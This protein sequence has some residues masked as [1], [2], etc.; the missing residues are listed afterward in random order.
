VEVI[1]K[2]PL[3]GSLKFEEILTFSYWAP[4]ILILFMILDSAGSGIKTVLHS[5]YRLDMCYLV[6]TTIT[7]TDGT[8]VGGLLYHV[9]LELDT[10]MNHLPSNQTHR[11]LISF[12]GFRFW[13]LLCLS[14]AW[15]GKCVLISGRFITFHY[16]FLP[17]LWS[18]WF[19]ANLW[20][21]G[22]N[23][24]VFSTSAPC[25]SLKPSNFKKISLK[26]LTWWRAFQMV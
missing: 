23:L 21:I 19:T 3:S 26:S 25:L 20:T 2:G 1:T 6:I 18:P 10:L 7:S 4:L 13:Y 12:E 16:I 24:N 9:E 11:P 22:Q 14:Y 17:L 15:V 8:M 5:I